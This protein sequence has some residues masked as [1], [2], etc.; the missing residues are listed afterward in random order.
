MGIN[1]CETCKNTLLKENHGEI[2]SNSLNHD[3]NGVR[4]SKMEEMKKEQNNDLIG[5]YLDD[6]NIN[7]NNLNESQKNI[8]DFEI[9]DSNNTNQHNNYNNNIVWNLSNNNINNN[10][11]YSENNNNQE[12]NNEMIS[13]S[14]NINNNSIEMVDLQS[15]EGENKD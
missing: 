12:N 7:N 6:E 5:N 2:I 3:Q 13:E 10:E 1:Y 8:I 4:S 14:N 11:S 15:N 9:G